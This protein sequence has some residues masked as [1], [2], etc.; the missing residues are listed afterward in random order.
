[1]GNTIQNR[2]SSGPSHLKRYRSLREY[3]RTTLGERKAKLERL[4]A[5]SPAGIV[6]KHTD[7]DGLAVFQRACKLGAEGIVSKRLS[8]P[9]HQGSRRDAG[10]LRLPGR[11]LRMSN[12]IE[13]S[14]ATIRHRA[15]R[16]SASLDTLRLGRRPREGGPA[17][18][19]L[20]RSAGSVRSRS[21]ISRR[22]RKLPQ[23]DEENA[24]CAKEPLL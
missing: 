4:L 20:R 5:R 2:A 1:M 3:C 14:F 21:R 8:A 15:V 16:S 10:F 7:K 23:R 18:S 19:T 12:V 22:R 11:A 17:S 9:Y 6:L 13:S 24:P